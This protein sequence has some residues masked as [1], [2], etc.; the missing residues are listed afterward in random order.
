MGNAKIQKTVTG[1]LDTLDSILDILQEIKG[2][3]IESGTHISLAIKVAGIETAETLMKKIQNPGDGDITPDDIELPELRRL[4]NLC[5]LIN[6]HG[7]WAI[8]ALVRLRMAVNIHIETIG[9]T[10]ETMR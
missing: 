4:I 9:A 5:R 8:N 7:N 2:D 6:I 1:H 3:G 10:I